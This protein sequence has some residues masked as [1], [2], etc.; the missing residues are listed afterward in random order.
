MSLLTALIVKIGLFW[1][2]FNFF[3]KK[4]SWTKLERLSIPNFDFSEKIE[5]VVI[6]TNVSFFCT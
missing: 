3:L 5:K 4:T 1:V 6:K 2:E